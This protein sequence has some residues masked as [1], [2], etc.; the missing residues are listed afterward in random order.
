MH[1]NQRGKVMVMRKEP[2]RQRRVIPPM[3]PFNLRVSPI[4][5]ILSG[6]SGRNRIFR[7]FQRKGPLLLPSL[8]QTQPLRK[9]RTTKLAERAKERAKVG[10]GRARE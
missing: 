8:Q 5:S 4:Y 10:R 3:L 2:H 9:E 6:S 1:T 7:Y